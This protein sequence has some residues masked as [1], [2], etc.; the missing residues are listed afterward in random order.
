[1]EQDRQNDQ[2]WEIAKRFGVPEPSGLLGRGRPPFDVTKPNLHNSKAEF[3]AE[4]KAVKEAREQ[5]ILLARFLSAPYREDAEEHD[6]AAPVCTA[7]N[8]SGRQS[9][10]TNELSHVTDLV[11]NNAA[12][13]DL[14]YTTSMLLVWVY[15]GL[16]ERYERLREQEPEF[17]ANQGRPPNHYARTIA[18]RFAKLVA[19]HTGQKPTVGASRD[20]GHPSTEFGRAI[21][22]IFSILGIKAEVP[23]VS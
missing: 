11:L 22:E 14:S 2:L 15:E 6:V 8:E 18:L 13:T 12:E 20:G 7:I 4:Q 1:M 10:R 21:E 9:A 16:N 19:K 17:W 23:R 5:A 3:L